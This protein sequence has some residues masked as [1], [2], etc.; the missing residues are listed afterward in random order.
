MR[1][2]VKAEWSTT[3]K[4]NHNESRLND[5]MEIL[6]VS[7]ATVLVLH[8]QGSQVGFGEEREGE[9]GREKL[10]EICVDTVGAML[11]VNLCCIINTLPLLNKCIFRFRKRFKL[12]PF[13]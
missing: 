5:W 6:C 9:G 4:I 12:D 3:F 13:V 7:A 10:L 8:T 11:K 2:S 1:C